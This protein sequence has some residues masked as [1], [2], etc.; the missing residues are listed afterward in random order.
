MLNVSK[1]RR[2]KFTY[3][4]LVL[5]LKKCGIK[6]NDSVFLTTNISLIGVPKTNTK[7]HLLTKCQWILKGLKKIIGKNGNIFVPTYSYTFDSKKVNTFIVNKT[8]SKIGYFPNFF[9]K[10]NIIR[11]IDPMVSVSGMG[12]KA[13]DILL[14]SSHTSYGK[15]CVFE[16]LLKIKNLKCLTIGLGINWV[17][18]IHYLDWINQV[19]FRYDKYFK[20]YIK[21]N[22]KKFILKWHYPVRYLK[23]KSSISDGYKLGNLAYKNGMFKKSKIGR[24]SIYSINY[25]DYFYFCKKK[26][27]YNK[28][29]TSN[30]K[31]K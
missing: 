28:F 2:N 29:L 18:F 16:R 27:K 15:D 14:N 25:Q 30:G 12:S 1:I 26:T 3:S 13:E 9:L 23:D 6:K 21:L 24:S 20:G 22:N 19:P 8:E 4:D 31:K 10:E 7:N 5:A 17:P 11:N